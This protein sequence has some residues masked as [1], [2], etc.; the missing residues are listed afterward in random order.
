MFED[1]ILTVK[2]DVHFYALK[3]KHTRV[4]TH[5]HITAVFLSADEAEPSQ[6]K[7][8]YY[9]LLEMEDL[10]NDEGSDTQ[11]QTHLLTSEQSESDLVLAGRS[12]RQGKNGVHRRNVR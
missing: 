12:P 3:H 11:D 4:R 5:T 6:D 7:K 1:F 9:R 10:S 2:A 8:P